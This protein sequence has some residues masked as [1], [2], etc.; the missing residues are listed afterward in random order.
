MLDMNLFEVCHPPS[1]GCVCSASIWVCQSGVALQFFVRMIP[2][3]NGGV[4]AAATKR[5]E[6]LGRLSGSMSNTLLEITIF[7]G[8]HSQRPEIR[9]TMRELES[10]IRFPLRFYGQM[11]KMGIASSVFIVLMIMPQEKEKLS[12][13][14]LTDN[15]HHRNLNTCWKMLVKFDDHFLFRLNGGIDDSLL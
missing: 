14:Q 7:A 2:A 4:P 12:W 9:K 5:S 3:S 10:M 15:S 13:F 1:E 8:I 6:D 11:R